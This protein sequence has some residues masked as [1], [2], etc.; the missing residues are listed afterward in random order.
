MKKV[1]HY[2][3]MTYKN[4]LWKN[5]GIAILIFALA[6]F[7]QTMF[8]F[9]E[10]R[11]GFDIV[12]SPYFF[13]FMPIWTRFIAKQSFDVND[14]IAFAQ[15][16]RMQFIYNYIEIMKT[17]YLALI[18]CLISFIFNGNSG[19]ITFVEIIFMFSAALIFI[20]SSTIQNNLNNLPWTYPRAKLKLFRVEK[21]IGAWGFFSGFAII[22]GIWFTIFDNH[23]VLPFVMLAYTLFFIVA[24][25][26]RMYKTFMEKQNG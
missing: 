12:L 4:K 25:H 18:I 17:L 3:V 11:T 23:K 1:L 20:C 6:T 19:L 21:L 2:I 16:H 15:S 8:N 13:I 26:R 9:L 7:G 10:E 22:A 14:S 5:I 24:L